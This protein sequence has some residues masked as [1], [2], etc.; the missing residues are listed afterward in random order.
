MYQAIQT[1]YFG[2]SNVRGSRIKAFADAGS[3]TLSWD[4]RLN[5]EGNH[6]AAA[7]TLASKLGWHGNYFG[8]TLPNQDMAFIWSPVLF[9]EP[10]FTVK[11]NM[12]EVA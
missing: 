1:R 7:K 11:E 9:N 12:E 2:P 6:I 4:H 10:A 8:G 5:P 3:V